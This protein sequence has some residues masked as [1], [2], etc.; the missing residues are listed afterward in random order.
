MYDK[1]GNVAGR[2]KIVQAGIVSSPRIQEEEHS[3]Q[4][5]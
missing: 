2:A 3:C 5:I 1:T 4:M